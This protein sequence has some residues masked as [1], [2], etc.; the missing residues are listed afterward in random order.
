M[1][2]Y[3][4]KN[5]DYYHFDSDLFEKTIQKILKKHNIIDVEEYYNNLKNSIECDDVLLTFDDGTYDHYKYVFPILKKYNISGLFFICSNVF[6][7]EILDIQYIHEIFSKIGVEKF[8]KEL[9]SRVKDKTYFDS[10]INHEKC[11]KNLLQSALPKTK[12]K[13][14][15]SDLITKYKIST[16]SKHYYL[17]LEQMKKMCN[18]GMYFGV[19]TKTHLHL[20]FFDYKTQWI[21]IEENLMLLSNNGLQN[22]LKI[23]AYPFG[24][25]NDDTLK[26]VKKLNFDLGFSIDKVKDN[27]LTVKRLDCNVLK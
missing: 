12:R 15:L 10:E 8:Y 22:K 5:Y 7:D 16:D 14:I 1:F 13:K 9:Y 23:I 24:K 25:F 27:F 20:D 6:K 17:T 2:H 11:I 19:H 26:I 3:V 18:E 21:E 4:R